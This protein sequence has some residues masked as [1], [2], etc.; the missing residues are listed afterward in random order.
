[1]DWD[2]WHI[3]IIVATG[4]LVLCGIL[5]LIFSIL[6]FKRCKC[7]CQNIPPPE[8]VEEVV[9]EKPESEYIPQPKDDRKVIQT[10][11]NN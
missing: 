8:K 5:S 3:L 9:K 11:L 1:M 4:I 10:S 2:L 7:K 6:T